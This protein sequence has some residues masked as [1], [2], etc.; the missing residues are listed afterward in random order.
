[1]PFSEIISY[2]QHSNE[3]HR[4]LSGP[5]LLELARTQ[6]IIQRYLPQPPATILDVGGGAGVYSLWLTGLRYEVHLID[7]T[8]LHIEQAKEAVSRQPEKPV[9]SV[10]VGDA[11]R[12]AWPEASVDAV[13]LLGPLYRLTER[14]DRLLALREAHRV[15]KPGGVLFAAAISRFAS[16]LD[17]LL[18]GFL[19]DPQFLEIVEQDLRTG[20][21]RNP[22]LEKDYFTTAYF[23]RPEDLQT[24]VTEAGFKIEKLLAI[25]GPGW[26]MHDLSE[27]W[28]DLPLRERILTVLRWLEEEPAI[29]G[30]SAHVLAVAFK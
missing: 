7:A 17:G 27:L 20:Q 9:V 24:E 25:E 30:A 1:M 15:L 2:Y 28:Q 13:L 4:L 14:A 8:P 23:H 3:A 5:G 26:L 16:A 10:A 6:E 21:H 11:R 22:Y 12:L 29:M 18:Q 19:Q